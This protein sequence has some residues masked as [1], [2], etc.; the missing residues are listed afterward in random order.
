MAA[1][2]PLAVQP[3]LNATIYGKSWQVQIIAEDPHLWLIKFILNQ[4]LNITLKS[5][6]W[7]STTGRKYITHRFIYLQMILRSIFQMPVNCTHVQ[8]SPVELAFRLKIS[9]VMD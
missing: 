5:N 8:F 7:L 6:L 3:T 1:D 4:L 9:S 2:E